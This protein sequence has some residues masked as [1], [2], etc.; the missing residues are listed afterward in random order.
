MPD[1]NPNEILAL[2]ARHLKSAA[3]VQFNEF[4]TALKLVEAD[5]AHALVR[6]PPEFLFRS[7]GRAQGIRDVVEVLDKATTQ[8]KTP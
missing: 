1:P 2:A 5:A 7:Q 8:R 6:S 3:G 4:M